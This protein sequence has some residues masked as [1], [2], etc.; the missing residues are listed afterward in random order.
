MFNV[1]PSTVTRWADQGKLT[2]VRT[3]GGHRR[4]PKEGIIE[5]VRMAIQ[6]EQME[7]MTVAI[8]KMYG[9][10]HVQAVHQALA[11]LAGIQQVWASAAGRQLRV[12]YDPERVA[13]TTILV[14]L[15]EAGYPPKNGEL[16]QAGALGHKDPAWAQLGLRMTETHPADR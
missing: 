15:A 8:P 10:H 1:S 5:L 3:L 6:E 7:T 2:Y 11:G 4:Y 13:P 16:P 9:D 12:T 14:R